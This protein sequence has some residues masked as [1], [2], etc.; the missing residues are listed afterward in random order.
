M[1]KS[2][3][4]SLPKDQF[5]D[6]VH[7]LIYAF[8]SFENACMDL[9]SAFAI[10]EINGRVF[11][12]DIKQIYFDHIKNSISIIKQE[13]KNKKLYFAYMDVARYQTD[14]IDASIEWQVNVNLLNILLER[15]PV[16]TTVDG[17]LGLAVPQE[18]SKKRELDLNTKEG[19]KE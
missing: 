18:V 8:P 12:Q 4:P 15:K 13:I 1:E 7:D 10:Q 17:R 14:P 19:K 3:L 9:F 2:S 5:A 16:P 11:E 6:I